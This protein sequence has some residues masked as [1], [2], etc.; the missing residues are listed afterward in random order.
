M[1]KPDYSIATARAKHL[2]Q[3]RAG[4]PRLASP[5]TK[6]LAIALRNKTNG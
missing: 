3:V 6:A 5:A 1:N 4:T 2:A